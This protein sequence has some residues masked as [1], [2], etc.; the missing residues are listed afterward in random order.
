MRAHITLGEIDNLI[1]GA[2]WDSNWI[3]IYFAA[4]SGALLVLAYTYGLLNELGHHSRSLAGILKASQK[5]EVAVALT[6]AWLGPNNVI[7]GSS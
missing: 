3:E 7:I 2:T 1:L 4:V 5:D 6:Y